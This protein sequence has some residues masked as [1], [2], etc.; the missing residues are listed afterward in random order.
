MMLAILDDVSTVLY[1]GDV[2]SDVASI[3]SL[4]QA[5]EIVGGLSKPDK[6]PC[7]CYNLPA[8]RCK[9][10]GKL[11]KV[12]GSVCFGCYAADD[13]DWVKR[14]N[15]ANGKWALT[16]YTMH[17]VQNALQRRYESLNDPMWVPAMI[18][19]IRHYA[20][21]KKNKQ[22]TKYFR[23][24]DSGDV[25]DTNHFR[26][27]MTVCLYTPSVKHWMPTREYGIVCGHEHPSNLCVRLSA[28][29]VDGVP[30][31][32]GLPTSTVSTGEAVAGVRCNAPSNDG[33]CGSC[34]L[35]WDRGVE[36]VDYHHHN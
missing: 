13:L 27:I 21:D 24:H 34:R 35:C 17:T 28:H 11:N 8:S 31:S 26:N 19:A 4:K 25:Q 14:K 1:S 29:M 32:Y 30:P 15:A 22:G 2:E 18:Y 20:K 10:G 3:T 23:W 5:L 6:M 12:P 7:M 36:N 9:M 16:R 33:R